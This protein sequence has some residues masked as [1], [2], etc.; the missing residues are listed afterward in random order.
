MYKHMHHCWSYLVQACTSKTHGQFHVAMAGPVIS[1]NPMSLDC[2]L[3]KKKNPKGSCLFSQHILAAQPA[4][5]AAPIY[6]PG[7]Q[8]I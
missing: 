1:M 3:T 8:S 4:S 2:R 6:E 5:R 7:L